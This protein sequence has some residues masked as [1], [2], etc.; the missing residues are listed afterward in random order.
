MNIELYNHTYLLSKIQHAFTSNSHDKYSAFINTI[1]SKMHRNT[2]TITPAAELFHESVNL[3]PTINYIESAT[4]KHHSSHTINFNITLHNQ[5]LFIQYTPYG[6]I[7][8]Q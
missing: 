3:I 1:V 6:T 7:Q 2:S 4:L 5:L 8:L